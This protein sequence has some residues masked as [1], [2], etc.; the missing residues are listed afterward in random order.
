MT[1][2]AGPTVLNLLRELVQGGIKFVILREPTSWEQAG[3]IDILVW[4]SPEWRKKLRSLGFHSRPTSNGYIKFIR[5]ENKWLHL[6]VQE[7]L[8]FGNVKISDEMIGYL[9]QSGREREGGILYLLPADEAVLYALHAS[10][11][12]NRFEH[13]YAEKYFKIDKEEII[14]RQKFDSFM[15]ISVDRLW[16]LVTDFKNGEM[17]ERKVIEKIRHAFGKKDDTPT[18]ILKRITRRIKSLIRVPRAIVF[19]GPDGAGKSTL[20]SSLNQIQWPSIRVQYMGPSKPSEMRSILKLPMKVAT[21]LSIKFQA[22]NPIGMTGRII[23]KIICYL[24]L[25]ERLWRHNWFCGSGG[26]VFCDRYGCDVFFRKPI[27]ANELLFLKFFPKP[28]YVILCVGNP[29]FIY[30]RK[31]EELSPHQISAMIGHYRKILSQYGIPN[32]EIN[33]TEFSPDEAIEKLVSHL[34]D[35][36]WMQEYRHAKR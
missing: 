21:Y 9:F 30:K 33:T 16:G 10:I 2:V 29:N 4:N 28:R 31:P 12:K 18:P 23:W 22:W 7:S 8:S 19:L 5:S 14:K 34:V 6:D 26:V 15:P 32:I 36:N 13:K 1:Q 3:D 25:L 20:I 24:D 27:F 35:N 17:S 11:N